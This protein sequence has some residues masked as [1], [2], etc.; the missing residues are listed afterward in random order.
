MFNM[1]IKRQMGFTLVE[2][3]VTALILGV[4][5]LGIL[6]L[7]TRSLQYNHQA[8]LK[9]QAIF[10]VESVVDKMR[11]NNEALLG[12]G[13]LT[14]Y[15]NSHASVTDNCETGSCSP[16]QLADWDKKQWKA[17]IAAALPQG[18]GEIVNAGGTSFNVRIR[19]TDPRI[20]SDPT[21][22]GIQPTA[23]QYDVTVQL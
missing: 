6:A 13:Y 18:E 1:K 3:I 15:S 12:A 17:D 16:S 20:D 23:E 19:F 14:V 4:G 11:H 22:D 9:S 21:I 10:L 5:M 7:Q 2:V 8:Y